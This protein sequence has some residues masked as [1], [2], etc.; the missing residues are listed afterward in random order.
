VENLYGQ[1]AF[2]VGGDEYHWDDVVL[3][4]DLREEWTRV[5]DRLRQGLACLRASEEREDGPEEPEIES[6]ATEFRYSRDLVAAQ[7]ME[8]WLTRWNVTAEGWMDYVRWSLLRQKWADQIADLLSEYSPEDGEVDSRI[9]VEAVCSGDLERFANDLAGRAA[10]SEVKKSGTE[11]EEAEVADVL[12]QF[13]GRRTER[14]LAEISPGSY[15]AKMERLARLEVSFRRFREQVATPRKIA[16]LIRSRRIDWTRLDLDS[17]SFPEEQTAREAALCVREDGRTLAE[18]AAD[19]RRELRQSTMYIE[20]MEPAL[21]DG[22]VGA[23]KGELLGPFQNGQEFV[24]HQVRDK[25]LPSA[26]DAALTDRARQ[27]V[28]QLQLDREINDRVKWARS[29]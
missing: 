6:A 22:F 11:P 17:I 16:A 15:Q 5:R 10:V 12:R 8:D 3:A 18:V 29:T 19:A 9:H 1:V 28:L 13:T 27:A 20:E 24:L 21:R 26:G 4:A 14:G 23:Q 7:E 2:T 25:R